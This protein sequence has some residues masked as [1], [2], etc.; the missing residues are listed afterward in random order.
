MQKWDAIGSWWVQYGYLLYGVMVYAVWC[1]F[2]LVC[3]VVL[4]QVL[5]NMFD[6]FSN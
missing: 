1:F 5:G 3:F 6:I 4:W 2:C